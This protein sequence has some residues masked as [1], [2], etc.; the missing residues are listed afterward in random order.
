[1]NTVVIDLSFFSQL[2]YQRQQLLAERQQFHQEQLKAAEMRARAASGHMSPSAPSP[3]QLQPQPQVSQ[4]QAQFPQQHQSQQQQQQQ[5]HSQQ[6][7]PQGPQP[8]VPSHIP[9]APSPAQQGKGVFSI[10][11]ECTT[12]MIKLVSVVLQEKSATTGIFAQVLAVIK[13]G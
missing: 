4:P 5:R 1:M 3:G 8:G 12:E 6:A 11:T 9:Q 7:P 10:N 13:S 2:E